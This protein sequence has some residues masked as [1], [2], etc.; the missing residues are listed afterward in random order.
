MQQAKHKPIT[1]LTDYHKKQRVTYLQKLTAAGESEPG[2][3]VTFDP[4]TLDEIHH[5]KKRTGHPRLNWYQVTLQDLWKELKT[6]HPDPGIQFAA[7]LD[8]MKP[9]HVNATKQYAIDNTHAHIQNG[10]EKTRRQT[11]CQG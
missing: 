11:V 1:T 4:D 2:T 9:T 8:S 10:L 6:D 5:G 3:S 7:T